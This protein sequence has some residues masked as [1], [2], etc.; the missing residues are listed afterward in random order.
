MLYAHVE[1]IQPE[2]HMWSPLG[3]GDLVATRDIPA[4]TV[5]VASAVPRGPVE[6]LAKVLMN[7]RRMYECLARN[8][9]DSSSIPQW[10]N[11][12]EE[13]QE[14][15]CDVA[16]LEKASRHL[17]TRNNIHGALCL[18]MRHYSNSQGAANACIIVEDMTTHA[19]NVACIGI[20]TTH[21]VR[22]GEPIMASAS[23]EPSENV[24]RDFAHMCMV[25]ALPLHFT[26]T[27]TMLV[28]K[29]ISLVGGK[30]YLNQDVYK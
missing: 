1:A 14:E 24:R 2:I 17:A 9:Q 25:T 21:A 15:G 23:L 29:N 19:P 11:R 4:Y 28:E 10:F 8:E 7:D 27:M 26:V 12:F 6:F 20:V 16:E 5:L 13:I 3:N 30:Y 18:D 22:K